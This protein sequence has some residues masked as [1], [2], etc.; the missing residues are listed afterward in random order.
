MS[1]TL[2]KISKM[3]HNYSDPPTLLLGKYN[4]DDSCHLIKTNPPI[5][6]P[7]LVL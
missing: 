3:N 7:Y 5:I 6:Y 4:I 2:I 1:V